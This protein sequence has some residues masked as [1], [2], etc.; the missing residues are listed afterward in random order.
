MK[1]QPI[2][3]A[4]TNVSILI[5]LPNWDHY[6]HGVYR[7]IHVDMGTGQRWHTTAYAM[8][9]DL[10]SSMNPTHWMPLPDPPQVGV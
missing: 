8:G 4:P 1:W 6:G 9:R 7:A 3:T 10:C 2:E 5:F